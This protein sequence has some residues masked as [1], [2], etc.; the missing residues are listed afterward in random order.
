M[1]L[2][3]VR[4][5]VALTRRFPECLQATRQTACQAGFTQKPVTV[6]AGFM[7]NEQSLESLLN[8]RV[9]RQRFVPTIG[10]RFA[11][12]DGGTHII[13]EVPGEGHVVGRW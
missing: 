6:T 10:H 4:V 2:S 5:D 9:S 12:G 13:H 8:R 3:R 1:P 7:P 11:D